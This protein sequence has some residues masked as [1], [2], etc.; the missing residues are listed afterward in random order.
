MVAAGEG[1]RDTSAIEHPLGSC[2]G[3]G[4]LGL[5]I[6][7]DLAAGMGPALSRRPDKFWGLAVPGLA[8]AASFQGVAL[9]GNL[10]RPGWF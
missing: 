3:L 6:S 4:C 7:L 5:Q 2:L 1:V 8:S 9:A 10:R